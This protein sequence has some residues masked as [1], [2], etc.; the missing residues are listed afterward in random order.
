MTAVLQ[1]S[2]KLKDDR[3]E[4]VIL[5]EFMEKTFPKAKFKWID[6]VQESSDCIEKSS[7]KVKTY[8]VLNNGIELDFDVPLSFLA[9]NLFNLD[10]FVYISLYY[11]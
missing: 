3:G 1:K 8:C 4:D 5:G 10:G 2:V 6:K 7:G 9:N 11:I